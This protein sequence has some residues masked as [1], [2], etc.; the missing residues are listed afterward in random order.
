MELHDAH[1][2]LLTL[3]DASCLVLPNS[4]TQRSGV[5]RAHQK[6]LP[7]LS[8]SSSSIPPPPL[9]LA[10]L[11]VPDIQIVIYNHIR[12]PPPHQQTFHSPSPHLTA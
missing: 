2:S 6:Q 5:R 4:S 1:C 11:F 3:H 8:S 7:P 10:F 12:H 9:H